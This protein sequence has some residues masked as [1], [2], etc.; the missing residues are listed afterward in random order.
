MNVLR[1]RSLH[2]ARTFACA[3][4]LAVAS[5]GAVAQH[6]PARFPAAAMEF[7][8]GEMPAMETAIAERDRDY[9]EDAMARMLDF[10]D[11]WGFKTLDNPALAAYPM[12]T[13]AVSDFLVVGM[14]RIMTTS[15][16]CEPAL[17]ARF[18]TN[19]KKCRDLAA[20]Q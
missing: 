7:L 16:A 20:R 11:S 1:L 9:F 8:G 3:L 6:D 19:M 2:F 15:S 14:C 18:D 5:T 13:E 12:C 10:S 17:A 4:C